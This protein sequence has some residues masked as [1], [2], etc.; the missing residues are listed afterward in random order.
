MDFRNISESYREVALD[1]NEG[2]D[3]IMVKPGLPYIDIIEKIRKRFKIPVLAYQV[4]G[5]YS[6]IK[7]AIS[8]K[9]LD[10]ESIF[11]SIISLKRA[12]ACAIVTYF[13]ID[14]AKKLN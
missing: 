8:K 5:E 2:A 6:M 9:I 13:A 7:N 3:M 4:S 12:G 10:E 14:I 11:E 1:I